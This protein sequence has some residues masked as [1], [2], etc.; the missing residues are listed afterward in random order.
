MLEATF[1]VFSC[2]T[3]LAYERDKNSNPMASLNADQSAESFSGNASG[4]RSFSVLPAI[5]Y[6]SR[7]NAT[8]ERGFSRRS[9]N[10]ELLHQ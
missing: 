5:P 6:W 2:N 10:S 3:N 7:W 8:Y 4:F 9:G 1:A